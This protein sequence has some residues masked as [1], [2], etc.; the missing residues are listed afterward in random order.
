[1]NAK[2]NPLFEPFHAHPV[3][4]V[5]ISAMAGFMAEYQPVLQFAFFLVSGIIG[6]LTMIHK[7]ADTYVRIKNWWRNRK[8]Q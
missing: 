8:K 5:V 4:A 7:I 6:I 1:M 3:V 2:T